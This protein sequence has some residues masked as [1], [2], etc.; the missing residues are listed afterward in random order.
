MLEGPRARSIT[1][2]HVGGGYVV[3]TSDG[4]K[5]R[6]CGLLD[7]L[8]ATC[9]PDY[10]Y[11]KARATAS[12]PAALRHSTGLARPWHGVQRGRQIHDEVRAYIN[13]G[14]AAAVS[15]MFHNTSGV[16]GVAKSLASCLLDALKQCGLTPVR[17]EFCVYYEQVSLASAIDL[18]CTYVDKE[19]GRLMLSVVEIKCGFENDFLL[20]TGPLRAPPSLSARYNNSPLTQAYLQLAFYRQMVQH[21]YPGVPIGVCYVAKVGTRDTT[22]YPLPN[23]IIGAAN[24][25]VAHVAATRLR[26]LAGDAK[27]VPV[28]RAAPAWVK[29]ARK[30]AQIPRSRR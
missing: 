17:S 28:R 14:G 27:A 4:K 30:T 13:A 15:G 12:T 20:A 21:A 2:G 11:Q 18:L 3:S 6:F 7:C 29:R 16:G 8:R 5:L 23:D 9:F 1:Q 24:D 10:D 26:Q 19:T 25:L 22:L